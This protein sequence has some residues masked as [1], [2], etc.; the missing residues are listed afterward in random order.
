M[1]KRQLFFSL[2]VCA[3]Q[4]SAR[5]RRGS[6]MVNQ[7]ESS[8]LQKGKEEEKKPQVEAKDWIGLLAIP[9]VIGFLALGTFM[10][11]ELE[12]FGIRDS[13]YFC[14]TMLTTVGYGDFSPVKFT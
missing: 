2:Q 3:V 12:G 13:L 4:V 8:L 9:I 6:T 5:L 11:V 10:F 14:V 7:T 1:G